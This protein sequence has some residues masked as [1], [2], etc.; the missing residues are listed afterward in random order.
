M[1]ASVRVILASLLLAV[2]ARADTLKNVL[3]RLQQ[4]YDGTAKLGDFG[5]AIA[6]DRSRLTLQ[7]AMVGTVAYM[8][9]EQA[10][11]EDPD[12]RND[13]YSLGA[14]LYE[15]V[16]G[17][18]VF[19]G[20]IAAT[21]TQHINTAPQRPSLYNAEVPRALEDVILRLLAKTAAARPASAVAVREALAGICPPS[22]RSI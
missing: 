14:M 17:R 10:L 9:P 15:M 13:L 8:A 20:D 22:P 12:P 4:R 2:P 1:R 7:G 18:R 5:L 21:I 3:S 6:L 11:G 19:L 16:T